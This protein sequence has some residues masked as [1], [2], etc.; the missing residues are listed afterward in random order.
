MPVERPMQQLYYT[1]CIGEPSELLELPA[2]YNTARCSV[3]SAGGANLVFQIEAASIEDGPEIIH[4]DADSMPVYTDG[5]R[6]L[7]L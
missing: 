2:R 6:Y 7:E 1:H 5:S 4:L 3:Q